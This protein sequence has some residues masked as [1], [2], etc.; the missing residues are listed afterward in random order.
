MKITGFPRDMMP[1]PLAL[2][3]GKYWFGKENYFLFRVFNIGLIRIHI[4]T[5]WGL[6][7]VFPNREVNA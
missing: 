5:M 1:A 7:Y 4:P 6:K 2:L 3:V